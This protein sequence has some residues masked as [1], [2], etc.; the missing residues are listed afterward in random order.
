M[1]NVF[2]VLN[3]FL[4][5]TSAQTAEQIIYQEALRTPNILQG[6]TKHP[7]S[8]H[9]EEQVRKIAMHEHVGQRLPWSEA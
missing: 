8:E 7:E 3:P 9:V 4:H 2:N 6:I 5:Q 1:R